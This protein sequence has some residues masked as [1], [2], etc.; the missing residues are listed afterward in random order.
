M[1]VIEA[2]IFRQVNQ[3]PCGTST[4]SG[5]TEAAVADPSA[6]RALPLLSV[7]LKLVTL[8]QHIQHAFNTTDMLK[9]SPDSARHLGPP[10]HSGYGDRGH[11]TDPSLQHT[12]DYDS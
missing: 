10:L 5:T 2:V 8:I 6:R 12:L 11:R 1:H 7:R 9:Y 4:F 3:H